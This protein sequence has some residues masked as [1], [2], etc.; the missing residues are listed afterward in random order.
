MKE[1]N[2]GIHFQGASNTLGL[3]FYLKANY[4]GRLVSTA[5]N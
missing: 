5:A 1:A 4:H 2:S 3:T